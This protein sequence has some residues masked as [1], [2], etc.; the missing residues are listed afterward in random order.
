MR[1][2]GPRG[3]KS[4]HVAPYIHPSQYRGRQIRAWCLACRRCSS[5]AP[6]RRG[7]ALVRA[8]TRP[9]RRQSPAG[10]AVTS[11]VWH[12]RAIGLCRIC[13]RRSNLG[14]F[15]Q[16]GRT[17]YF[18]SLLDNTNAAARCS[19]PR[20]PFRRDEPLSDT[21]NESLNLSPAVAP[22]RAADSDAI[23]DERVQRSDSAISPWYRNSRH[24]KKPRSRH[25]GK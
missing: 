13:H 10:R 23:H 6:P 2:V 24:A 11:G 22:K 18:D 8:N 9:P 19:T 17:P 16:L 14:S 4:G 20:G 15:F 7:P 1:R 5:I 3:T 21:T 12:A 25:A